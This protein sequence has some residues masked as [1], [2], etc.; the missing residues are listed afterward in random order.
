MVHDNINNEYVQG[1]ELMPA[2][3]IPS[4]DYRIKNKVISVS[5]QFADLHFLV[6]IRMDVYAIVGPIMAEV[7]V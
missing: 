2:N 1:I 7:Q 4:P 3:V 5:L 6:H